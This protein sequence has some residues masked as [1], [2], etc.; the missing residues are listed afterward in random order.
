MLIGGAGPAK[1]AESNYR[2]DEARVPQLPWPVHVDEATQSARRKK[3]RQKQGQR[4]TVPT[5][6]EGEQQTKPARS[7]ERSEQAHICT[8]GRSLQEQNNSKTVSQQGRTSSR[9]QRETYSCLHMCCT[10]RRP[11]LRRRRN[12]RCRLGSKRKVQN[13]N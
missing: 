6:R 5:S 9:I 2:K 10:M 11:T 12:C 8:T 7:E 1:H 13:E 4:R 3:T